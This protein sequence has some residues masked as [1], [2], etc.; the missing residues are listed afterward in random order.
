MRQIVKIFQLGRGRT[1][2]D[3][4]GAD[5][6]LPGRMK[7]LAD[8]VSEDSILCTKLQALSFS[9]FGLSTINMRVSG[10]M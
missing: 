10:I 3:D 7:E 8:G 9:W 4:I 1:S 2:L 5:L 6:V